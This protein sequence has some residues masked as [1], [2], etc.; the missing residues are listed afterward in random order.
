MSKTFRPRSCETCGDPAEPGT[1]QLPTSTG[2]AP[3]VLCG[4]CRVY[5]TSEEGNA[6]LMQSA[7][8]DAERDAGWPS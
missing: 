8:E 7:A 6:Q 4:E 2:T 3:A 5:W 1:I